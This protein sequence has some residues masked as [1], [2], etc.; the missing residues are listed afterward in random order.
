MRYFLLILLPLFI[1]ALAAQLHADVYKY[2]D[3]QGNILFTDEPVEK[4]GHK[5]V[6]HKAVIEPQV[7][8]H[9]RKGISRA[10]R[11]TRTSAQTK[12]PLFKPS[13]ISD[14]ALANR[15][16]YSAIIND[17]A[18]KVKLRPE[19]LH[20]VVMVESRYNPNA[21]SE[22][23]AKGLMQLM[24]QTAKRYGVINRSD[25][26]QNVN[27]GAKYLS[28]L[29][30]MFNFNLNLALAGYNAGENAVI[31]YGN[32]IPPYPETQNYVKK[33]L[34]YYQENRIEAAIA[35]QTAGR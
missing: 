5:L 10:K 24:P 31:K 16:L 26:R 30:K 6:W 13:W 18:K 1:L 22:A 29:L 14:K 7:V 19:L 25:P 23:G 28:D 8:V 34:A 4:S 35:G 17:A 11:T 33:V 21:L 27:G 9:A 32:K 20:A 15:K 12:S 2:R 3:S